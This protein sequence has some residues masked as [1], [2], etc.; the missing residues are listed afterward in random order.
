MVIEYAGTNKIE[1]ANVQPAGWCVD[2][3][4]RG[5]DG[6]EPW[7]TVGNADSWRKADELSLFYPASPASGGTGP[8]PSIR[9]KSYRRGQQDVEYLALLGRLSGE[10]RWATGQR[11]LMQLRQTGEKQGSGFTGGEDA[12]IISFSKLLP[13]ELWSLRVRVATA[14]SAARPAA[15]RR[16]IELRTPPRD[17]AR[18]PDRHVSGGT[19]R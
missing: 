16:L 19:A 17:P 6:V 5:A 11:V 18:L 15:E 7:Q 2:A 13:Q 1:E 3:W 12:G 9:L 8:V 10:P 14:I 4:A